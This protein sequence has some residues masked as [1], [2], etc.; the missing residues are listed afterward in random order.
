VGGNKLLKN[1]ALK[2]LPIPAQRDKGEAQYHF[3]DETVEFFIDQFRNLGID[4]VLCIGTPSLHEYIRGKTNDLKMK[5][6]LLDIDERFVRYVSLYNIILNIMHC[7]LQQKRF[8]VYHF[9]R[10]IRILLK[11]LDS[12][13]CVTIISSKEKICSIEIS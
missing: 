5:S 3:T 13:I 1:M 7:N 2:N 9:H 11:N 8:S 10:G 4:S 6:F 12:T